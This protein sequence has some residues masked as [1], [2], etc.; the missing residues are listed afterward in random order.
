[1]ATAIRD[2]HVHSNGNYLA[3][4]CRHKP[5]GGENKI[6]L[7]GQFIGPRRGAT[8]K[9]HWYTSLFYDL[10]GLDA[11]ATVHYVGQYWERMTIASRT[12]KIREWKTLDLVINYT[13]HLPQPVTGP[14]P[15]Y[16]KDGGKNAE[17]KD[18]KDK[19]IMPVFTAEYSP[20]G[21]RAWLNNTTITLGMNN[22]FD[23]DPPFVGLAQG[24][25]GYDQWS[26]NIRGRIWYAGIDEAFLK[27]WVISKSPL[28][29]VA[30]ASRR[31]ARPRP[32]SVAILRKRQAVRLPYNCSVHSLQ[33]SRY[34][35]LYSSNPLH[36]YNPRFLSLRIFRVTAG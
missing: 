3:S 30:T 36:P 10:G 29:S 11:G 33:S 4:V 21:W 22:V 8:P 7:D 1:M 14:V 17:L 35:C 31:C 12:R 19:N 23:Q 2:I 26:A 13:F 15:G 24:E 28:G 34:G 20:S 25:N 5:F 6:N 16:A 9:N 32:T 27:T 18:R